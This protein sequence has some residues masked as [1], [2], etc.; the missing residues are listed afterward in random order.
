MVRWGDQELAVPD[1][2]P[3][4][5]MADR[6]SSLVIEDLWK[7]ALCEREHVNHHE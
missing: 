2:V 3:I 4:A 1:K 6:Q 7:A 5:G